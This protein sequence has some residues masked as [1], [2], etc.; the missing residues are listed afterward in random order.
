VRV[1]L[2]KLK[3]IP[4]KNIKEQIRIVE[5]VMVTMKT[6]DISETNA[7]V[8]AGARLVTDRWKFKPKGSHIQKGPLCKK[9]LEKQIRAQSKPQQITGMAEGLTEE[10]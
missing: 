8:Y 1:Q 3:A 5:A 4:K 9:W 2:P 7:L 10:K 6:A